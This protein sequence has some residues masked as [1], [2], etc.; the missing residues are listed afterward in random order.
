MIEVIQIAHLINS[1]SKL[2]ITYCF[3]CSD[4]L[5]KMLKERY[6]D[7]V[8]DMERAAPFAEVYVELRLQEYDTENLPETLDY[9]DV[10]DMEQRMQRSPEVLLPNL[11]DKMNDRIAPK[12]LL[13]RGKAGVGK[14]T[15]VRQIASQWA[16]G[17]LWKDQFNYVFVITLRELL[18]DKTWTL[19]ELLLDGL[20]LSSDEKVAAFGEICKNAKGVLCLV[21]GLD[22]IPYDNTPS[23]AR[24]CNAPID[25][26]LML[27]S[28]FGN[29]MLPEST[30]LVTSRPN[31]QLP[32]RSFQR[33]VELYGFPRDSINKYVSIL[34][35]DSP[36]L[37]Q[38]IRKTFE[39]N[40]NLITY[41]YIPLQCQFLCQALADVHSLS[42]DGD[43]P[44]IKTM[45]QLYINA[46]MNSAKKLH[47]RVKY[48]YA[49][50]DVEGVLQVV[51]DPFRK[52]ADL[53]KHCMMTTPLRIIFYKED[54]RRVCLHENSDGDMQC[55]VM[56][57][58]RKRDTNVP[59]MTS[60]CWS[61]N[62][63]SLQEYF[64]AIG[65]LQGSTDDIW[66]LF[67]DQSSIRKHEVVI[68]FLAGLS[69]DERNVCY[70]NQLLSSGVSLDHRKLVKKLAQVLKDDQLKVIAILYETQ[71][72]YL[73]DIVS[74]ECKFGK[75]FPTEMRA[76]SWVLRQAECP[77]TNLE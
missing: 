50:V 29:S 15:L 47:P 67:V 1:N 74:C 16:E 30:I 22:E 57:Q 5:K 53:A 68:S 51:A 36:K 76:L 24:D 13:I 35:A 39:E 19:S 64:S 17:N 55:G 49:D 20:P 7:M 8:L 28:I 33:T 2:T 21:D 18:Q 66:Q 10:V 54:L 58:S 26:S 44:V 25:L 27:S 14:T 40:Q 70:M 77:V 37:E 45:T 72:P 32:M 4:R 62:H 73:V 59:T 3:C 63:L 52:Y 12:K 41:C 31:M 34:S 48:K 9:R 43:V 23:H 71:D 69:G 46:T 60:I 42:V 11:F 38:F 65:L 75:V 6:S 56:T 61:F